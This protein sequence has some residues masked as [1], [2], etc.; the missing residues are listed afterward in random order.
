M[1][2]IG[3]GECRVTTLS[4]PTG[5]MKTPE[6]HSLEVGYHVHEVSLGGRDH[7]SVVRCL[8]LVVKRDRRSLVEIPGESADNDV[9]VAIEI[10]VRLEPIPAS[11]QAERK[12]RLVVEQLKRFD[13]GE[14]GD[15]SAR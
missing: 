12:P 10:G 15:Q 6:Q 7:G 1:P 3:Y 13:E 8:L 14:S 5:G 11:D 9:D 2:P 4:Q